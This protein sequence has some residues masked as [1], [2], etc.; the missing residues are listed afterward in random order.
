MGKVNVCKNDEILYVGHY[1]RYRNS[2]GSVNEDFGL[3]DRMILDLKA[4]KQWAVDLFVSAL[5]K[6][7]ESGAAVC[8]VPS[9]KAAASNHSGIAEVARHLTQVDRMNVSDARGM[10]QMNRMDAVD[11]LLRVKTI[12]KLADGGERS[13]RVHLESIVYN[14][15]IQM[16][17]MTAYLLDDVSTSGNSMRACREI[18]LRD[19]RVKRVVMMVVGNTTG[20]NCHKGWSVFK[21]GKK[22]SLEAWEIDSDVNA[23]QMFF[24]E[25]RKECGDRRLE[26]EYYPGKYKRYVDPFVD[27][28]E[29]FGI[30]GEM[31]LA[32]L[33]RHFKNVYLYML[34]NG[35][36]ENHLE[37]IQE[38]AEENYESVMTEYLYK[39]PA[40]SGG[41]YA[42]WY[43]YMYQIYHMVEDKVIN[44]IVLR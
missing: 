40:P 28:I 27:G 6:K 30:Y 13:E 17:G 11:A 16:E 26:S 34:L 18:L 32:Y 12:G 44:E 5:E 4:G 36:L 2:D 19:S 15:K 37:M 23:M 14:D 42:E 22:V 20:E 43:A 35:E 33:K 38:I 3:F 7:I 1:H 29:T 9:H 10:E 39:Y 31:R 25:K 24:A 8:V 41:D 21:N